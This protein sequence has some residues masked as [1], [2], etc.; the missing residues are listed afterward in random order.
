MNAYQNISNELR[1][2]FSTNKI[3]KL[4]L[5]LDIIIMFV[6]LALVFLSGTLGIYIGSILSGLIYW[7]FILGL[8][9]TY[10]NMK[11]QFLYIG[12]LGYGAVKLVDVLVAIIGRYHYLDWGSLYR[13]VIFGGLG[14]L[15]LRKTM[16]TPSSTN[17]EG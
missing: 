7:A 1:G 2:F 16:V 13:L 14:Y 4:L 6:G 12:L 3:F 11:E 9:L 15:V 17:V 8:L 5:P 10:A